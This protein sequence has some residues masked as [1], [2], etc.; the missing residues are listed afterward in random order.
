MIRSIG[1]GSGVIAA[2]TGLG[3]VS[4]GEGGRRASGQTSEMKVQEGLSA[5][6]SQRAR[7]RCPWQAAMQAV[8]PILY[9]CPEFR[10]TAS[11]SAAKDGAVIP[12][13]AR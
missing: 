13:A 6:M 11:P 9:W 7:R 8:W 3:V 10:Q 12:A 2:T 4:A 1:R 5:T